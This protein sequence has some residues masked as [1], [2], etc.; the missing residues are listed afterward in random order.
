M[1]M[2]TPMQ[3]LHDQTKEGI[4]EAPTPHVIYKEKH[5]EE[6]VMRGIFRL[7]W[8]ITALLTCSSQSLKAETPA[9]FFRGKTISVIASTA[10]GGPYDVAARVLIQFMPKHIPG[11]PTLVVRNMPGG[12][13]MRAT[14]YLYSQAPKD[15]TTFAT[16]VNSIAVHQAVGGAGAMYD[17][18]R[19]SWIGAIGQSNL[20]VYVTAR[21]GIK[22]IADMQKREIVLG[23]TGVGSGTFIYANALNQ[24]IGTKFKLIAGYQGYP[25]IDMAIE[26]GEVEGMGGR[27]WRALLQERPEWLE[28]KTI[29]ILT[30]VGPKREKGL[31]NVPLMEEL[32][33]NEQQKQILRFISSPTNAGRPYLAPP[34]VPADRLKALRA[35]F[36]ATM[37]DKDYL[38]DAVKLGL[39]LPYRTGAELESEVIEVL[40]TPPGLIEQAKAVMDPGEAPAPK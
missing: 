6:L 39:D 23:A 26:R 20:T 3:I 5:S 7:S 33:Q 9:E 29:T 19:F 12:G 40:N 16:L 10:A 30:Q 35:A 27:S 28:K 11:N 21:S 37:E 24:I 25:E 18:R 8:T 15:G 13:H 31:E 2:P 34:D 1:E 14:N 17:A 36:V 4:A 22:S 32:G 38:V